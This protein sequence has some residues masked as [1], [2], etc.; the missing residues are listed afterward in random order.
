[1]FTLSEQSFDIIYLKK[2]KKKAFH[3]LFIVYL[4]DG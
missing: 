3:Q 1:M 4:A 2:K